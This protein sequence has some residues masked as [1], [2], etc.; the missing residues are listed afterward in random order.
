VLGE[1]LDECLSISR[2]GSTVIDLSLELLKLGGR[3][4]LTSQEEPKGSLREGL[5]ATRCLGRLLSDLVEILTSVC[6]TVEVVKLGCLIEKT[7]HA[8]HS[9]NDLADVDLTKDVVSVLLLECV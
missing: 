5:R 7:G 1:V 8:S 2:E 4:E 6:D 3:G 9:T